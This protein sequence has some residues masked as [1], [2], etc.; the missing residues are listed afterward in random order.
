MFGGPR[1][2]ITRVGSAEISSNITAGRVFQMTRRYWVISANVHNNMGNLKEWVAAILETEC[3]FINKRPSAARV[4]RRNPSLGDKFKSLNQDDVVLLAYGNLKIPGDRHL[5]ACGVVASANRTTH[6][7]VDL[8]HKQYRLLKPF[9]PLNDD[10]MSYGISFKGTPYFGNYQPHA[11][12]ELDA[13]DRRYP[14]NRAICRCLDLE[15]KRRTSASGA[16]A[17]D[18]RSVPI[19]ELN[20]VSYAFEMAQRKI[21]A[22]PRE[23][24]LVEA[25][26]RWLLKKGR[27]LERRSYRGE[28]SWLFCDLWEPKRNHL[29]EA[30]GSVEREAIRMAIDELMDYRA[31]HQMAFPN[32]TV[33]QLGLLV[34]DKPSPGLGKLL[35]SLGIHVVFKDGHS[36]RD[37]FGGRF[38]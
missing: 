31:L 35:K 17:L 34:P 36:F 16:T 12:Y 32:E 1:Y 2:C 4:D 14:G 22:E 13:S 19:D 15:L 20:T 11:I 23:R 27:K 5:V 28:P 30:K 10:P 6:P 25:Y 26:R 38:V 7:R 24:K 8:E 21:A 18:A 37:T 3:A 9:L 29:I 33:Q